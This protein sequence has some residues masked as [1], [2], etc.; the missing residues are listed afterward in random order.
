MTRKNLGLC[1][2]AFVLSG[3]GGTD[4]SDYRPVST[5]PAH[6]S[7][8]TQVVDSSTS[9]RAPQVESESVADDVELPASALVP[10]NVIDGSSVSNLLKGN[11]KP[12]PGST[13]QPIQ[14]VSATAADKPRTV[15]LLIPEKS[16]QRDNASKGLRVSYDDLDLLKVLNLDPVTSNAVELMPSWLKELSGQRIRIRGFMY[17]TFEPDG[18][19]RFVL[20]RDNQICCFGRDPKVYDLVQVDLRAGKTTRYIPPTRAFDVVGTFKIALDLVD[21]KPFG[22]YYIEDAEIIEK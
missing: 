22:L 16:F 9:S 15:E 6:K 17:P 21:D 4:M 10:V 2:V 3:C 19:E 13:D 11:P 7:V 14:P 8:Q 1:L 12:Q 5:V 20:A 18:I